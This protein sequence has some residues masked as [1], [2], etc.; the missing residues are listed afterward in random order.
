VTDTGAK[1]LT[2]AEFIFME[3]DPLPPGEGTEA[4]IEPFHPEF[5]R[6]V[7]VDDELRVQEASKLVGL[8]TVL[9]I[10]GR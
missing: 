2:D 8:A 4:E 3:V 1:A 6:H 10:E 5:W 7:N 9:S